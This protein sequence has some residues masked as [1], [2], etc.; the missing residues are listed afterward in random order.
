MARFLA[1]AAP[2]G[3]TLAAF[4]IAS[5]KENHFL[6]QSRN[7]EPS[8]QMALLLKN[9]SNRIKPS[10]RNRAIL[11]FRFLLLTKKIVHR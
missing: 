9:W 5:D 10:L 2:S 7:I 4:S 6:D 8:N 11:P 1:S 3:N